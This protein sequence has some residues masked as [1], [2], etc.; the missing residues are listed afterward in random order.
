MAMF[1]NGQHAIYLPKFWWPIFSTDLE[2][3]RSVFKIVATYRSACYHLDFRSTLDSSLSQ[4]S[5][6][7]VFHAYHFDVLLSTIKYRVTVMVKK[8][9]LKTAHYTKK[10]PNWK[11]GQVLNISGADSAR[12]KIGQPKFSDFVLVGTY[13]SDF[14]YNITNIDTYALSHWHHSAVP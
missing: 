3:G 13:R 12:T 9:G 8:H 14:F 1:F 6:Y 7:A 4:I 5:T 11:I 10:S 2:I